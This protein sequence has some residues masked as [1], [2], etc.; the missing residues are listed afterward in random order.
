MKIDIT[1]L[2]KALGELDEN[3]QF[4]DAKAWGDNERHK[5]IFERAAVQAFEFTYGVAIGLLIR[6]MEHDAPDPAKLSALGIEDR[7]R[8]A[9]N[10]GLI[11]DVTRFFDYRKKRNLTS[12]N[13]NEEI[14]RQLIAILNPFAQDMR[15]LLK[16][17]QER[18][19]EARDFPLDK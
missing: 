15:F 4:L 18:N 12:H 3:L 1:P 7:F 2:E 6:Q 16:Q 13:Y 9:A 11:P 14:S 10:S 8:L 17:L 5:R 19:P